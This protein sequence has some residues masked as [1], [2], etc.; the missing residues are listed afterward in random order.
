LRYIEPVLSLSRRDKGA[1][2]V[3]NLPYLKMHASIT[4]LFERDGDT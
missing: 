3:W 1:F 4:K 2:L